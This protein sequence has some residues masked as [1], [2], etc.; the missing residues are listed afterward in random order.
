MNIIKKFN[1]GEELNYELRKQIESFFDYKWTNDKNFAFKHPDYEGIVFK[2]AINHKELL[3]FDC[4]Y[5]RFWSQFKKQFTITKA[6]RK[7]T[8]KNRKHPD[9]VEIIIKYSRY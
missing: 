3:Y 1:M 6:L 4:L 8:V 9:G 2:I 7:Y 5:H